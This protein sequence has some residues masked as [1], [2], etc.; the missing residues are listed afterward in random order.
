MS[1]QNFLKKTKI[2]LAHSFPVTDYLSLGPVG[3]DI[4]SN[5][6]RL[7]KLQ[8]KEKGYL[9]FLYKEVKFNKIINVADMD[10]VNPVDIESVVEVLKKLKK[11][12]KL[13]YVVASLPEE[14]NY[15]YRTELPYEAIEDIPSAIRFSM[16][17][18]VPL[19]VKEINFDYEILEVEPSGIDVVVSVFPKTVVAFYTD[20]LKRAGLTPVSFQSESVALSNAISKPEDRELR[21][22]VRFLGDRVNV[23]ISES[24]SV[25]Y[26]SSI[27][28]SSEEIMTDLNG[29]GM[30]KLIQELNKIL[31]YWFTSKKEAK[32]QHKIEKAIIVGT[33][34]LT[35]GLEEALEGG[36]KVDV[37]VAN[38][39]E[40]C[41]SSECHIPE[42]S[43]E[44]ALEYAVVIGLALKAIKYK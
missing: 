32:E 27:K 19:S 34:V 25:Q 24:G 18:N 20:I 39:W 10:E 31:I 5:A 21:L 38:V 15:I 22:L 11:Q 33:G 40:N 28:I 6:V 9:P 23:A 8:K 13:K 1:L 35:E 42:I 30:K 16:E 14:K 29:P 44:E 7:V 17:E 4:T 36:L 3:I 41:C 37:S 12:H 2:K 43:R 26:T